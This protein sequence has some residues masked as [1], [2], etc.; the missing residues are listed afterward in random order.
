MACWTHNREFPFPS[1]YM[2]PVLAKNSSMDLH[3]HFR[4]TN[5]QRGY[6]LLFTHQC[7]R[8]RI[9]QPLFLSTTA[10]TTA[11]QP[12]K[13]RT[14]SFSNVFYRRR[15]QVIKCHRWVASGHTHLIPGWLYFFRFWWGPLQQLRTANLKWTQPAGG[16]SF[17]TPIAIQANP[18]TVQRTPKKK[19]PFRSLIERG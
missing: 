12:T 7:P 11:I 15:N 3:I 17:A 14:I 10:T 16:F 8:A 6:F 1:V 5:T 9:T 18:N 19:T 2:P 13:K 4:A